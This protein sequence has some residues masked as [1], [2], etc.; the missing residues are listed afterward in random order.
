MLSQTSEKVADQLNGFNGLAL[1]PLSN[2]VFASCSTSFIKTEREDIDAELSSVQIWKLSEDSLSN[3]V[4]QAEGSLK[5][6]RTDI[7]TFAPAKY[8]QINGGVDSLAWL[9]GDNLVAGCRDH[10]IKIIDVEKSYV[11]KQSIQTEHKVPTSM[12]TSQDHLI[13]T[14]SEDAIIRLW[15]CRTGENRP[16]KQ[17]VHQYEGHN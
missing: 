11:T 3:F 2:E 17:M 4:T 15:D 12:D 10:A 16:A 5:R 13:L 8:V 14:G 1:N 6:Q 9:D 7:S